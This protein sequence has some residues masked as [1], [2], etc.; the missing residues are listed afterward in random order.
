MLKYPNIDMR[1]LA[2]MNTN[3]THIMIFLL[4]KVRKIHAIKFNRSR[5]KQK[6]WNSKEVC[7]TYIYSKQSTS[8]QITLLSFFSFPMLRYSHLVIKVS[9]EYGALYARF[10]LL[11]L[12]IYGN[13]FEHYW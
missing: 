9:S 7:V 12:E 3:K 1:M 6:Q 2:N 4:T 8:F 13:P 10:G 11:I 5:T